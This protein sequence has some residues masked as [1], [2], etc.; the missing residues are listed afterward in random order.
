MFTRFLKTTEST[1][2]TVSDKE[3]QIDIENLSDSTYKEICGNI[4][5]LEL[6]SLNKKLLRRKCKV[7]V[8]SEDNLVICSCCNTMSTVENC[9]KSGNVNSRY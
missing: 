2:I 8:T 4:V 3:I 5:T 6:D 7:S 9:V 1:K